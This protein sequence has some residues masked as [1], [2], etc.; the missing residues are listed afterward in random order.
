MWH[1]RSYFAQTHAQQ[2]GV[3]VEQLGGWLEHTSWPVHWRR[4]AMLSLSS[5]IHAS[6]V[7]FIRSLSALLLCP[8]PCATQQTAPGVC[9]GISRVWFRMIFHDAGTY[10]KSDETG[11]MDGSLQFELD[12]CARQARSHSCY[13]GPVGHANAKH[14]R[15][16]HFAGTQATHDH[17]LRL[18][19]E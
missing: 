12:R 13:P 17:D 5:S 19:A 10:N 9:G 2:L 3:W 18:S 8:V 1:G 14:A 15:R 7:N 6:G 11:G 4:M 16:V